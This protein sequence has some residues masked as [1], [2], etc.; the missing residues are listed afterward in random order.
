VGEGAIDFGWRSQVVLLLFCFLPSKCSSSQRRNRRSL[1]G[2]S[3]QWLRSQ[4]FPPPS[5]SI[6]LSLSLSLPL[7]FPNLT[8]GP[9]AIFLTDVP[10]L[11]KRPSVSSTSPALSPA[12]VERRNSSVTDP[13]ADKVHITLFLSWSPIPVFHFHSIPFHFLSLCLSADRGGNDAGKD[14]ASGTVLD[15]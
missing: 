1:T 8:D 6:S 14:K 2:F 15:D 5:L 11:M 13:F 12:P 10:K 4:V 7:S 9:G 3:N